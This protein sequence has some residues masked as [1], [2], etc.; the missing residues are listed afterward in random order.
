[1]WIETKLSGS[2]N[3]ETISRVESKKDSLELVYH[4]IGG[5]IITEKYETVEE[6]IESHGVI[7]TTLNKK[8]IKG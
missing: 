5:A 6:L 4:I 2:L 3:S 7:M 1:M 8:Y